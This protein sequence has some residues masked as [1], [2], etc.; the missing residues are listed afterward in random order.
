MHYKLPLVFELQPEGGFTVTSPAFPEFLTEG[1]SME[2]AVE[3]VQDAFAAVLEIYRDS[4]RALPDDLVVG[5]VGGQLRL[6]V[7][8]WLHEVIATEPFSVPLIGE[9]VYLHLIVAAP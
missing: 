6:T 5:E 3:N 8:S 2:D 9:P 4:R 7:E 1:D